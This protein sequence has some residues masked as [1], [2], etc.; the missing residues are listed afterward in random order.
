MSVKW[1]PLLPSVVQEYEALQRQHDLATVECQRVQEERDQAIQKL[2]EFQQ[3]SHMVIEEVNAIQEDLEVE[4][5]CRQTVEI[6]ASKLKRQNRSLKRKSMLLMTS[7]AEL[8]DELDRVLEEKTQ[9]LVDVDAMQGRLRDTREELLKEKH[10][11]SV[12]M[13][14]TVKQK[15]L[16]QKYNRVSVFAVEEFE[17]LQENLS[18]ERDL[19]TEA[20]RFAREMLVEQKKLKRQSQLLVQSA[21]PGQALQEALREVASLTQEVETQS[22][23]LALLRKK[24]D[25]PADIQLVAQGSAGEPET[26]GVTTYPGEV[27]THG[28]T[29]YPGDV[30]TH[31]VTTYP[32][33]VETHGVTTYPGDVETHGVTT[34]PGEV[35][36]HGVTTYP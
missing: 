16:L 17:V 11:N 12:L 29:T 4:R 9:A 35:E 1:H 13:G 6:L 7:I 21:A 22:S 27:E 31:G 18:L 26:H 23:L 14:E 28:V 10:D 36:T 3:V 34:Y 8:R 25:V 5:S 24:R 32:G 30:E 19:R 33:E 2:N 20:E 15:A